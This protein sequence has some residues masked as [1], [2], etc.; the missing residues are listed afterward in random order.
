MPRHRNAHQADPGDPLDPRQR[1]DWEFQK[2]IAVGIEYNKVVGYTIWLWFNQV[3]IGYLRMYEK[4]TANF[5]LANKFNLLPNGKLDPDSPFFIDRK[6]NATVHDN[7]K[8]LDMNDFAAVAGIPSATT[9]IFRK[10]FAQILMDQEDHNIRE[11]EEW[12]MNGLLNYKKVYLSPA[13]Y[14]LWERGEEED[15][16]K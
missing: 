3:D 5:C 8:P 1:E 2:G 9:Y 10:M 16:G 4:I 6:G 13:T 7:M 12:A 15:E 11:T 14:H